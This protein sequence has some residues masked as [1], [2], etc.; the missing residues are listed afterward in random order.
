M[1]T[2]IEIPGYTLLRSV[3]RGTFSEVWCARGQNG[4]EYAVKVATSEVGA[5]M[6]RAEV[7]LYEAL[8]HTRGVPALRGFGFGEVPWLVL[9]W[10][11]NESLRD[12][13]RAGERAEALAFLIAVTRTMGVVHRRGIAH[14]DL[15]PENVMIDGSSPVILDFGLAREFQKHRLGSRLSDSLSTKSGL[16]G[17]TLAYLPPE[18]VKGAE[19]S[20]AG[21]VYAL[22]VMLHEAL[23]GRRPDKAVSPEELKKLLDPEVVEILLKAL[24]FEPG[25]RYPD[26]GAL[27]DDLQIHEDA[28][29]A[30]GVRSFARSAWR[31][32]VVGLAAFFVALR[33]TSVAALLFLYG[34][35]IVSCFFAKNPLP[36]L[37]FIPMA[38]LHFAIRWEGPE[39]N[40][41]ASLRRGGLV[42]GRKTR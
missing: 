14:G 23:L 2:P 39:T 20:P 33:Y 31:F 27:L 32:G 24:A 15:K 28:L 41:E 4:Q 37:G 5:R 25:D 7:Q 6:L 1:S 22:G 10:L 38:L 11:G 18:A 21:D 26:A 3:S 42:V 12:V 29:T 34:F 17:G 9:D 30:T 19:P 35:L 8:S 16:E 13:L 36:L 40:E